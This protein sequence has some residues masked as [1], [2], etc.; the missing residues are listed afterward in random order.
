MIVTLTMNPALDT[1]IEL[2]APLAH[3]GVQRS[4]G[5][6]TQAAGK[7][8]NVSR[9]IASAGV[10]TLA[11][12]PGAET[13]PLLRRLVADDLEHRSVHI[14]ALL[15]TNITLTDPDGTT[16]KINEQG[17]VLNAAVLQEIV[18]VVV[19]VSRSASWL[20]LA[21]SLPPGADPGFYAD[22]VATVREALGDAAPKIA[23]DTSEAPLRALFAA[24]VQQLPDLIKP[25]AEE[26]AELAGQGSAEAF[27]DS[28]TATAAAARALLDRG[29]GT[30]LAT[31]GANGAVLV[32]ADGAW[33]ATHA[34]ITPR[35]TVGA[36]DSA[37]AGYLLAD[38]AGETAPGRL[39]R[40]VAYG[41]AAAS[42][43][44]SAIPT[45]I[46]LAPDAV[47]VEELTLIPR[48]MS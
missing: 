26:L 37:L 33:H 48:T 24:Q 1:T 9:A 38:E 27:E 22:L 45:P 3:G 46:Q 8:V 12:L 6:H 10:K 35:S 39:A 42:L 14:G 13:D 41:S 19:D 30:V 25:N 23:V 28:P 36:G 43:P 15:R 31:L 44:G 11:V 7:G 17:P 34:P 29:V 18:R 16:T 40:A 20:A 5:S 4:L 47:S 32:N 2:G 21:G